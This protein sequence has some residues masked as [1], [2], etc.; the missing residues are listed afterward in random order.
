M[1]NRRIFYPR[2]VQITSGEEWTAQGSRRFSTLF[3]SPE[4]LEG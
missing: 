1:E 3:D 2:T 4:F